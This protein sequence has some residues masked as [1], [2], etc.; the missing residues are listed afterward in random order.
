MI[1][2]GEKEAK[3]KGETC[4]QA[5]F[6]IMWVGVSGAKDEMRNRED[7]CARHPNPRGSLQPNLL[8]YLF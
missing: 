4:G 3:A 7:F 1:V 2:Q 6:I 8:S 5:L